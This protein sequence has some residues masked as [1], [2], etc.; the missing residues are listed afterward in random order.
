MSDGR[1]VAGGGAMIDSNRVWS[2]G[3]DF[4]VA[5]YLPDG[6]LDRT[7]GDG[8]R[9][10]V[11]FGDGTD[12]ELYRMFLRGDGTIVLGGSSESGQ[13]ALARLTAGGRL[14][15][16]FGDGGRVLTPL[17]PPPPPTAQDAIRFGPAYPLPLPDGRVLVTGSAGRG[18][19]L[20]R[21]LDD[22][23]PAVSAEVSDRVLTVRGTAAN[24]II[25][26]RRD[27]QNRRVEVVGLPRTFSTTEFDQVDVQGLGGGDRIDLSTLRL[28]AV[29]DGGPG[30]DVILGGAADDSLLGSAGNDSIFGGGGRDTLR[31]GD[32]NDYLN[33]GPGGDTVFG[34]AGSDQIFAPDGAVDT[35]DGGAGFDRVKADD[36]DSLSGAEGLLA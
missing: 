33:A 27:T 7:F 24:D 26:M 28:P 3:A 20:A 6:S 2:P 35:V 10:L 19:F 9:T 30:N 23:D 25:V 12:D 11:P 16:T 22:N 31:G 32:G 36:N 18:L 17:P 8:G 5:R 15:A 4:A 21:Y 34:D 14:D 13:V 29:V 1:I